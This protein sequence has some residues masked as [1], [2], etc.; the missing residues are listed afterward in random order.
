MSANIYLVGFMGSGKTELAPL[1]AQKMGRKWVD[2]DKTIENKEGLSIWEIFKKKGEE[3]FRKM[4]TILLEELSKERNLVIST[5]GGMMEK[6][7]NRTIMEQS[8]II[9]FLNSPF[10]ICIERI[11]KNTLRPVFLK[12]QENNRRDFLEKLY[13]SRLN[14]YLKSHIKVVTGAAK[15]EENCLKL[16]RAIEE[17]AGALWSK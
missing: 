11:M 13:K 10:E 2:T 15:S 3:A 9:V 1:V 17:D 4:E 7:L 6:Q 12:I 5:G 16:V 8:G 14:N